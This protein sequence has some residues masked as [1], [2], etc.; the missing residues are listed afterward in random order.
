VVAL[1][2]SSCYVPANSSEDWVLAGTA[3]V[4]EDQR[5]LEVD[6]ATLPVIDVSAL[7]GGSALG[8]RAVADALG[9]AA[10][11]SGCRWDKLLGF[12]CAL[13]RSVNSN[14]PSMP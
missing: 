11:T 13:S 8:M 5:A 14:M 4:S 10:R 1:I 9:Q 12:A 2:S 3:E 6:D 7:Q